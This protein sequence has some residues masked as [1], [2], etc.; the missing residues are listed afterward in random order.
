M[1]NVERGSTVGALAHWMVGQLEQL[2]K[3]KRA[4][5]SFASRLVPEVVKAGDAQAEDAI[6]Q[7]NQEII[8]G[9]LFSFATDHPEAAATQLGAYL[10]PTNEFTTLLP[11]QVVQ[12]PEPEKP[13]ESK[14]ES[15]DWEKKREQLVD[16]YPSLAEFLDESHAIE[17]KGEKYFPR[18]NVAGILVHRKGRGNRIGEEEFLGRMYREWAKTLGDGVVAGALLPAKQGRG[19][20]ALR[21]DEMVAFLSFIDERQAV[22]GIKDPSKKKSS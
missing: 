7:L 13:E 6:H 22:Y 2:D 1:A 21:I 9:N 17:F 11:E 20:V 12:L 8:A 5:L 14:K 10:L 16:T 19:L 3:Q 18:K 15:N 4:V